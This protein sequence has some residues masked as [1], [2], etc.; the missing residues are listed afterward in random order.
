MRNGIT[1]GRRTEGPMSNGAG[2]INGQGDVL[3]ISMQEDARGL[4]ADVAADEK[5][6]KSVRK[7]TE[8]SKLVARNCV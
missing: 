4:R 1:N 2:L 3:Y 8:N 7:G 5:G 6:A